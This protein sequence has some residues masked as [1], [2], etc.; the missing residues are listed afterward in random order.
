[1]RISSI[2]FMLVHCI[3]IAVVFGSAC[4]IKESFKSDMIDNVFIVLE[5]S[6]SY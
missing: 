4:K 5:F 6:S 2:I 3:I 1:M